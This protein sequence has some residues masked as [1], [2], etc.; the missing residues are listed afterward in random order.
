MRVM[1]EKGRQEGM[2]KPRCWAA[3]DK[4][5]PSRQA[6]WT[7]WVLGGQLVRPDID[8][9]V[10]EHSQCLEGRTGAEETQG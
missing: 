2:W 10:H 6:R 4:G 8:Q 7:S 3:G 5:A 9:Q 1:E